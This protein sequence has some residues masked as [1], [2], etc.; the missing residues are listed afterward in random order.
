MPDPAN[1][2]S[3]LSALLELQSRYPAA[4]APHEIAAL[5]GLCSAESADAL[6]ALAKQGL[7]QAYNVFRS[8]GS[9][10]LGWGV[11]DVE[12]AR[13]AIARAEL[14]SPFRTGPRERL[15]SLAA[16]ERS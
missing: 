16:G 9:T 6:Q 4:Q 8:D 1:E 12:R 7:V 3:V 5:A 2:S 11:L 10:M 13:A 14:S 15:S